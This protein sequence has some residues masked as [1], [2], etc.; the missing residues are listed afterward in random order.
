MALATDVYNNVPQETALYPYITI[1][2]IES[3]GWLTFDDSG[4]RGIYNIDIYG[5]ALSLIKIYE[6]ADRIQFL[7]SSA[8]DALGLAGACVTLFQYDGTIV[9]P[10]H[11]MEMTGRMVTVEF[12]V[13]ML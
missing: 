9:N 6:I 2:R 10:Y 11:D 4:R 3:H 7:L 5:K 13:A 1:G 12:E 8:E